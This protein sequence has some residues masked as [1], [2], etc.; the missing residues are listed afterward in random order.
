MAKKKTAPEQAPD[1][2]IIVVPVEELVA[3]EGNASTDLVLVT[4]ESIQAMATELTMRY[5]NATIADMEDADLRDGME[6]D[7]R[8]LVKFRNALDKRRLAVNRQTNDLA[9]E[10]QGWF[11]PTETKL[12]G[13]V[14]EFKKKE[15]ARKAEEAR[16]KKEL[17][18]AREKQLFALKA[19]WLGSQYQL[20]TEFCGKS[21]LE[22]GD[23]AWAET[24]AKFQAERE[25]L[26]E[27]TRMEK[28]KAQVQERKLILLE[29]GARAC[30]EKLGKPSTQ[31]DGGTYG[32]RLGDAWAEKADLEAP[33]PRWKSITLA[34][35]QSELKRLEAEAE[36]EAEAKVAPSL[37]APLEELSQPKSETVVIEKPRSIG[38]TITNGPLVSKPE[39]SVPEVKPEPPAV[40]VGLPKFILY[41]GPIG[42]GR[43]THVWLSGAFT[44]LRAAKRHMEATNP[45]LAKDVS[46]Q[47]VFEALCEGKQW[48]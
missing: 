23:E 8:Q 21:A 27:Q 4:K 34:R 44:A 29:M 33:E 12:S 19:V 22:A 18:E 9:S 15:E 30:W 42:T 25:R 2:D 17:F 46:F 48:Q 43:D 6:R 24:L 16:K 37:E 47:V 13:I 5:A 31:A 20:G 41:P 1:D 36:V 7:L 35:F 32:L 26:D 14:S 10:I 40:L 3:P 11:T 28:L 45:A 39:P 38:P